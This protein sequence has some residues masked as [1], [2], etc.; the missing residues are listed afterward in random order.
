MH[1]ANIDDLHKMSKRQNSLNFTKKTAETQY[2]S[3]KEPLIPQ[4]IK[5]DPNFRFG[6]SS[7][8]YNEESQRIGDIIN[9]EY[10][11]DHLTESIQ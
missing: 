2:I 3:C 1:D 7:G 5:Q 8:A 9:Y 4:K 11:K 10:L 6:K